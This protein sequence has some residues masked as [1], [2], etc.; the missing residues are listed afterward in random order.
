VLN[1]A[2]EI[3]VAAFLEQRLRFLEIPHIIRE[4]MEAHAVENHAAPVSELSD[5]RLIDAWAK[6]FAAQRA[7]EVKSTS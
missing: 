4:T 3:A 7:G 2:N 6:A 5:V 1:A